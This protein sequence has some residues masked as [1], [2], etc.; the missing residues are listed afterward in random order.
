M[1]D[2]KK[3]NKKTIK[4]IFVKLNFADLFEAFAK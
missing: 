1:N 2:A 3:E 4:Q